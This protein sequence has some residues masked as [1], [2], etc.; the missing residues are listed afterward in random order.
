[1][2]K[3]FLRTKIEVFIV[4]A[5]LI[6]LTISSVI[7]ISR[8]ITDTHD[9]ID[10]FIRNSKGNYWDAN[11]NNIQD[12]IDDLGISA[13]YAHGYGG[14]HGYVWLPG[15][16]TLSISSTLDIDQFVT[17]DMQ[18]SV[19]EPTGDFDAVLMHRG[20]QIRNGC[21]DVS[22]V[23]NYDSATILFDATEGIGIW[24]TPPVITNMRLTSDNGN[25][26]AL[27]LHIKG[28]D[29]GY[30]SCL[31]A[32]NIM[33]EN[34]EYGIF[35]DRTSSASGGNAYL[36][37]NVFTDIIITHCTYPIKLYTSL[38]SGGDVTGNMFEN[39]KVYCDSNT[40]YVMWNGGAATQADHIYAIDWDNNSGTRKSFNFVESNWCYL[41]FMGGGD[42]ISFPQ[43][44]KWGESHCIINLEDSSMVIGSITEYN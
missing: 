28:S 14:E 3:L 22:G 1:M 34:F 27:Y 32:Y 33:M 11:G 38:G 31:W 13:P 29:T 30:I 21:I 7:S 5:F 16:T 18:G 2:H 24:D 43:W 19:I 15:N 40:E 26:I 23:S 6:L 37:G 44:N 25:G 41:C 8:T 10:L 20:S 4:I 17:L 35:L 12:A 42:D 36:N 39:I 9:D